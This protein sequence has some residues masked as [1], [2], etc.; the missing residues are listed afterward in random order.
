V[1]EGET[2]VEDLGVGFE[3]LSVLNVY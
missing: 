3:H 1:C 2:E